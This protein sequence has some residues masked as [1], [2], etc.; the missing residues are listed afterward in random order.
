MLDVI[1]CRH[2]AYSADMQRSSSST[3]AFQ[4]NCTAWQSV[5]SA[6]LTSQSHTM[7][8][9]GS[10]AGVSYARDKDSNSHNRYTQLLFGHY[11]GQSVLG[12]NPS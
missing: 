4:Q 8:T 7:I 11:R 1:R 3:L 2:A 10:T 12:S 6:R 5:T 9:A